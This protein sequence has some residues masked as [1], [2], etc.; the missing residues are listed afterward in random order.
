MAVTYPFTNLVF[1]GGGV[2]GVAYAGAL[3]VL[4]DAGIRKQVTAVAGTSAGAITAALVA[5][6]YTSDELAATMLALDLT[7]FEDGR[8]EGPTRLIEKYGWYRGEVFH[9]WMGT[10]LQTKLGSATITFR[11]LQ[12]ATGVDL[13][14]VA[15]DV[16]TH[17]PEIFSAATSPDEPVALAVRMSMS[18]PFFFAAVRANGRVYVDGGAVWNYPIEIFDDN[19]ANPA[20]LGFHLD[21]PGPPP[22]RADVD[23][24]LVF[25]KSLYE[26]VMA[27]QS[28][29][30]DRSK[31]DQQR[32]VVI[33]DLNLRA[34]DF[35]I[36]AAKK[37]ALISNGA[38]A[39]RTFLGAYLRAH[40]HPTAR[41]APGKERL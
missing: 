14:V 16:S 36:T 2:K 20:T 27:V 17:Q 21:S 18:I 25:T 38:K 4:E 40:G 30:F 22:P 9:D 29:Y 35:S 32:T 41:T 15:T 31:A 8:L 1:E 24:L 11:E 12:A 10:Q 26:S 3:R 19:E 33:D 23:D 7:R 13:R 28:G 6:G 39:T 34:T 5:A 37:H